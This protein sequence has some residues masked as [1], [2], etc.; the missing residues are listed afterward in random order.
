MRSFFSNYWTDF[1]GRVDGPLHFRLFVQ[2]M[3]AIFLAARDGSRD[4][5]AGR[6]AYLWSLVS[7]PAQRRY[8]L[9]SGWKSISKVFGLALALDVIYQ[10]IVWHGLKPLQEMMTAIIL[11]V[12]PYAILRGPMNR[13]L[14]TTGA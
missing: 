9:E 13:L 3:M 4:A 10:I 5:H 1:I 8:L 14:R 6:G 7:D 11:A 2:P 12:I